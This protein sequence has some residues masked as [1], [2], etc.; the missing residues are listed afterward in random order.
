[1]AP[2]KMFIIKQIRKFVTCSATARPLEQ[3]NAAIPA[4]ALSWRSVGMVQR[5]SRRLQEIRAMSLT[6]VAAYHTRSCSG[7]RETRL[8]Y[9]ESGI[10]IWRDTL[11]IGPISQY[12][13]IRLANLS[14]GLIHRAVVEWFWRICVWV[15]RDRAMIPRMALTLCLAI[16]EHDAA[17]VTGFAFCFHGAMFFRLRHGS[18]ISEVGF[19]LGTPGGEPVWIAVT[20][21]VMTHVGHDDGRGSHVVVHTKFVRALDCVAF[22]SAFKIRVA[23][24]VERAQHPCVVAV[25]GV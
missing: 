21:G 13:T 18:S 15:M 4:T 8:R 23:G 9:C 1:L 24:V 16:W 17:H 14:L 6:N 11:H 22:V 10:S 19:E 20:S 5:E 2:D 7:S 3:L 12:D 25:N